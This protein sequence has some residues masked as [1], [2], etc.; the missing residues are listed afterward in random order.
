VHNTIVI[1]DSGVDNKHKLFNNITIDNYVHQNDSWVL[2][3]CFEAKNGHGTAV[4]SIVL[5]NICNAK[6]ISFALFD[7]N[8]ECSADKLISCLTY[9]SENIN[10]DIINL[11]L[12]IKTYS[13]ELR[14]ICNKLMEQGV[15]IISAFS[16]DGGISYPAAFDFVI[17]VDASYRCK[18]QDDFVYVP[19][20]VVNVKAKGANQRVAWLD[21]KYMLTQGASYSCAYV[22]N[23]AMRLVAGSKIASI[24]DLLSE[25]E[26]NSI[27]DY[28][29]S[30][31][32]LKTSSFLNHVTA[33]VVFPFSK[34][35]TS[36]LNFCDMLPFRVVDFYEY[37]KFGRIGLNIEGIYTKIAYKIKNIED[38]EWDNFDTMIIGHLDELTSN[39][40]FDLKGWLLECCLEK[41]KNV[42]LLDVNHDKQL[43]EKFNKAGLAFD[44]PVIDVEYNY[45][46]NLGKLYTLKT[47]VVGVFGTSKQQGKFSVQL[48][49]R[50]ELQGQGYR[51]AHLGSEP[52]SLLF[53]FDYVFPFGYDGYNTLRYEQS[54]PLVNK[55]MSELDK[56]DV[57]IIVAGSQA[58]TIPH[59]FENIIYFSDKQLDFLLGVLPDCVVLCINYHDDISYIK[60]TIQV[61]E[62]LANCSVIALC[63]FPLGFVSEW[64]L[65][66]N[67]K[68]II[69][70][71]KL[72][73]RKKL[74]VDS[75]GKPVLVI[76]D[77]KFQG[78]LTNYVIDF[79]G[80]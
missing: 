14:F 49:L 76:G 59:S 4:A 38:C 16:N 42:Y 39:L 46:V 73:E 79:F 67:K 11:S 78:A 64:D 71:E 62:S 32:E 52:Q 34:E 21:N 24:A 68:S 36:F 72:N 26:K 56:K 20:G 29:N 22:S 55:Y 44:S 9:I 50:K 8:L 43:Q 48:L 40:E 10:C 19:Y 41:K 37:K 74:L 75:L 63:M 5:N 25:I 18:K 54:I 70:N 51:V 61:I 17:G 3:N 23:F 57:D 15:V 53:G 65:M 27:Y 80:G 1:I 69:E 12:G 58:G 33:T 31:V 7:D 30:L 60:R 66:M 77:T 45:S 47:P 2:D 13:D 6:T 28:N 35:T